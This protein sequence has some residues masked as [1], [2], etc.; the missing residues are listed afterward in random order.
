MFCAIA[1]LALSLGQSWAYVSPTSGVFELDGDAVSRGGGGVDWD[2]IYESDGDGV[3]SF[4]FVHDGIGSSI[5]T[6]GGSKDVEDV[7]SWLWKDGSVPDKDEILNSYAA[8]RVVDGELM[9]YFGADRFDN[10]GD[11][12]IGF[13]FFQDQEIGLSNVASGGGSEFLGVHQNDD[14]FIVT[15]FSNGGAIPTVRIFRWFVPQNPPN[16]HNPL[17]EISSSEALCHH[18]PEHVYACSISNQEATQ[19]PWEFS[20]KSGEDQVFGTGMFVEGGVNLNWIYGGQ[21]IPCFSSMMSETRSSTS[22]TSTL[23]DFSMTTFETCKLN[24]SV[25]CGESNLVNG[26]TIEYL[27]LIDIHN[28]GY[29]G[30]ETVQY[31]LGDT[32]DWVPI[33]YLFAGSHLTEQ[34]SVYSREKLDDIG[35]IFVE[36]YA[37]TLKLNVTLEAIFCEPPIPHPLV[38]MTKS[39]HVDVDDFHVV[40]NGTIM[41]NGDIDL[42]NVLVEDVPVCADGSVGVSSFVD[43]P[44]YDSLAV[45]EVAMY[46]GIVEGCVTYMSEQIHSDNASVSASMV[47]GYSGE[48]FD[49][50]SAECIGPDYTL[51]LSIDH[52]CALSL[53]LNEEQS[54]LEL[55]FC[56]EMNVTNTGTYKLVGIET[57]GSWAHDVGDLEK[58]ETLIIERCFTPTI[59]DAVDPNFVFQVN[60]VATGSVEFNDVQFAETSVNSTCSLCI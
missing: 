60:V 23:K 13:W 29:I 26:S 34:I 47:L 55:Y 15:E 50:V 57:S 43:G 35:P 24:G 31:K 32:G 56:E 38:Q 48:V 5:F 16:N 53:Q 25:A 6:S 42:M 30:F 8:T 12:S 19:S 1:T 51:G 37:S 28:D 3:D 39:C 46:S 2:L 20:P 27:L 11:A 22:D 54:A 40:F 21:E 45:G 58:G 33:G 49:W 7:S 18:E 17:I 10:S 59:E 36:A 9:L 52:Q 41:N 14:L 44:F 4:A